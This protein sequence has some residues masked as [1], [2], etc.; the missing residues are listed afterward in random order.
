MTTLAYQMSEAINEMAA[1]FF[2]VPSR[3]G[4]QPSVLPAEVEDSF[5]K[6]IIDFCQK[7]RIEQKAVLE[8]EHC[9]DKDGV[10]YSWQID[11][12]NA[13]VEWKYYSGF[14][15]WFIEQITFES[16]N[17]TLTVSDDT[18]EYYEVPIDEDNFEEKLN[19]KL[20]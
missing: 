16:L 8:F 2:D 9:L 6:Q 13:E 12:T 14:D 20:Y 7:E 10:H 18:E 15:D 17:C 11:I 3:I 1:S 5:I 4:N 19:N